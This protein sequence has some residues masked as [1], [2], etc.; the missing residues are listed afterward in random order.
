[1]YIRT[2]NGQV[3]MA[4]QLISSACAS[5][6]TKFDRGTLHLH[7]VPCA[8]AAETQEVEEIL[9]DDDALTLSWF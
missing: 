2:L 5:K 1:M 8:P 9:L 3:E 7:H 6:I 4:E